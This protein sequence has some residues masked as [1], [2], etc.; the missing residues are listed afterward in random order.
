MSSVET[1]AEAG[2]KL[3]LADVRPCLGREDRRKWISD[4]S[5]MFTVHSTYSFLLDRV[6]EEAIDDEILRVIQKLWLNDV[7]YKVSIF[8]WRLLLAKL[9]TRGALANKMLCV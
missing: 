7:M 4:K 2:L 8:G 3:L 5:C 6:V 9:S 1:A